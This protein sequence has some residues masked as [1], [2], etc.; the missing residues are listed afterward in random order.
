MK[1]VSNDLSTA[2]KVFVGETRSKV[3]LKRL[4]GNGWGR[5]FTVG[6]PTPW[7]GEHWGF[8]NGAFVNYSQGLPFD[9]ERFKKRL[10][11]SYHKGPPFLAVV[12]D[13]VG[14]SLSSLEF[15]ER[16]RDKLYDDWPWYLAVQDGMEVRD[17]EPLLG[18]YAGLF[19]G[20]T[21]AFKKTALKWCKLA[22]A[23]GKLFHYGRAGTPSKI[24]HA[25]K[26]GADSLDSAF[27]LWTKHRF[28]FFEKILMEGHPQQSLE[29]KICE[30]ATTA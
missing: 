29:L 14:G 24:S 4:R 3:M 1:S 17:V 30:S 18:R 19:L 15:S 16:W 26:I 5:M 22:H 12:P 20:G 13:E 8:D 6:K 28:D 7:S 27:P 2:I 11:A 9:E 10:Q 25:Q 21:D 23:Y